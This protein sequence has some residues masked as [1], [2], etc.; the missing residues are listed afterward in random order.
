MGIVITELPDGFRLSGPQ[1]ITAAA[2]DSHSDHRLAMSLIVAALLADGESTVQRADAVQ[3]SFPG[4]TRAL[5]VL[6]TEVH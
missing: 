4:F 3:E 5:R 1:Q 2:V 6:G